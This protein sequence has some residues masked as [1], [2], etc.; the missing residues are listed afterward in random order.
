MNAK[1]DKK[2]KKSFKEEKKTRIHIRKTDK[3]WKARAYNSTIKTFKK[4]IWNR[5]KRKEKKKK[6]NNQ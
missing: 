4:F 1:Q 6:T 2:K 3:K 5:R